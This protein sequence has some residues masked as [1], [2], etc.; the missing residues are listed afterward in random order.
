[1]TK[2]MHIRAI[3]EPDKA[4]QA[5]NEASQVEGDHAEPAESPDTAEDN[6]ADAEAVWEN[7]GHSTGRGWFAAV[8]AAAMLAGWT[9][10]YVWANASAMM[11]TT[12]P[13]QWAQWIIMWSVPVILI[14]LGWLVIMRSSTREASR[15]GDV[16]HQ[17]A[18]ESE[19]LENRLVSVNREL[20]LARE[21]LAAQSRELE[22]LGRTAAERISAPAEQLQALVRDN[23]AQIDAIA[24]VSV[25]A[26][27]NMTSLRDNLP[28]VANSARDASNQIGSAGRIAKNHLGELITG[29]ERLNQFGKASENQVTS[30]RERI[31]TALADF[32][33]FS[34]KIEED[35]KI[36][37]A[38]IRDHS[39]TFHR[40]LGEREKEAL[41][42]LT[43]RAETLRNE[44]NAARDARQAEEEAAMA[45]MKD[46]IAALAEEGRLAAEAIRAEE[47]SAI[48]TWEGQI[49]GLHKRLTHIIDEIGKL[50]ANAIEN[51]NS[52]LQ[53]L[54]E[55]AHKVDSKL[56]ERDRH[57]H[58]QLAA[59]QDAFK[60]AEDQ[61][62][63]RLR[64]RLDQLDRELAA[65]ENAQKERM[66]S[67]SESG[68]AFRARLLEIENHIANLAENGAKAEQTLADSSAL[69]RNTIAESQGSLDETKAALSEL[70]ESSVRVLEFIQAS[71]K[72][73]KT[74]LPAA[75]GVFE[76]RLADARATAGATIGL[77]E[78]GSAT[79]DALIAA[80]ERL[81]EES[82][83]IGGSLETISS[84]LIADI[85]NQTNS[86]QSLREQIAAVESESTALAEKVAGAL[87]ESLAEL[88]MAGRNALNAFDPKQSEQIEA[89]AGRVGTES[90]QA[91]ER[92]ILERTSDAMAQIDT[93][94]AQ[95]ANTSREAMG[96]LRDQLARVNELT[97]NLE[98]RIARAREQ[99]EEQVDNDFSRRV[100]LITESLN[101]NA[102]DIAKALST[103]VTDTAWAAYLRGDRSVFT[104]RAVKLLD[105]SGNREIAELYE[106]DHEFRDHVRRYIHDFEAMLRTMLST[107]D[108]NA[109]GVTLL[110]S[111]MGKLYVVLAQ[112]IERLRE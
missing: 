13:A 74:E 65:R 1:M 73:S 102:I 11:V 77:L 72:H 64:S 23:G 83:E 68:E 6:F 69:L 85:E 93:V 50:D 28:V 54:T 90:A 88:E 22:Y 63:E 33:S 57:F 95:A 12:A 67:L 16:A 79:S 20:S 51:A 38:A 41:A 108:G 97:I 30:L 99:A 56:L 58:D 84:K 32:E 29:F 31:D 15:F 110:S 101:S 89:L 86:L 24:A 80:V 9:G 71:A 45:A 26:L 52:K 111:D 34:Q 39:D 18:N 82:G 25:T 78:Q 76:A 55:E 105:S 60:T 75:L 21:F 44:V 19:R 4:G 70:T 94:T 106:T 27:E 104:R 98:S 112:A 81:Q 96:Q 17:L 62:L 53:A 14:A 5:D 66:E 3:G 92:A 103:E 7:D 42:A 35:T 87:R 100:A 107:R 36:R 40:D 8:L 46:H 49:N 47:R 91:I 109:L 48:E 61:A 59:R 2:R 37:L 43:E 10:F